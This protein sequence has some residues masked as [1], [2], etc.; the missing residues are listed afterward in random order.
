V[1]HWWLPQHWPQ[2]PGQLEQSSPV[3]QVPLPQ[4]SP[5]SCG[6]VWQLSG[7]VH[8]PSPHTPVPPQPPQ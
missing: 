1:S 3:S 5:Q 6:Q 7:A 8:C 2:S 4:H